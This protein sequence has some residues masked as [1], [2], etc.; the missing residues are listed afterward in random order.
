MNKWERYRSISLL[1]FLTDYLELD[2]E[3]EQ[4]KIEHLSKGTHQ[5]IKELAFPYVKT[6]PFEEIERE[7]ILTG[8]VILIR[9]GKSTSNNLRIA[10]YIRPGLLKSLEEKTQERRIRL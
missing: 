6:I 7:D 5:D 9:D 8:K 10:P 4:K 2:N 1:E 3:L